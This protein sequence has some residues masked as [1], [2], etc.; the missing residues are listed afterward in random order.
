LMMEELTS[1]AIYQSRVFA[2]CRQANGDRA[3]TQAVLS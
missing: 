3:D 2:M 1:G